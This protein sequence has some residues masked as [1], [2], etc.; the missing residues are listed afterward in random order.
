ML[1]NS[2]HK[3]QL[4]NAVLFLTALKTRQKEIP[5]LISPHLGNRVPVIAGLKSTASVDAK[6]NS[7][8][9]V[10]LPLGGRVKLD[11]WY[12]KLE[13]IKNK[14]LGAV[15]EREKM[16]FEVAPFMSYR[17]RIGSEASKPTG[18]KVGESPSVDKK[19][20]Q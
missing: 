14:A 19:K 16:P 17:T 5:N 10:A 2:P 12:D 15:A 13:L 6:Q 3:N 20:P 8:L 18:A 9:I 7:Q 11:P 4:G 1:N